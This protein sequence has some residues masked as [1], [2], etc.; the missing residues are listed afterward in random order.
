[1]SINWRDSVLEEKSTMADAI[2]TLEKIQYGIVF[3]LSHGDELVGIVTDGDI[4]RSLMSGLGLNSSILDILN[5]IPVTINVNHNKNEVFE[6][7]NDLRVEH[8]PVLDGKKLVGVIKKDGSEVSS[9]DNLVFIM[10]GGFGTRLKPLTDNIPKPMLNVGNRPVLETIIHEFKKQGFWNFYISTH[11]L[12]EKIQE[13]FEDGKK[14]GVSIK[15]VHENKPLGTAGA[16][17]LLPD[18]AKKNPLILMNGDLLTKV[19]FKKILDFHEKNNC[20][21]TL[22]VRQYDL[23]V[24][25]GVVDCDESIVKKIIE[26]PIHKF[27][28]NAGIYVLSSDI[29]ESVKKDQL[30][31][32]PTLLN[33]EIGN[34]RKVSNFPVH[35]YWLDIGRMDQFNQAQKDIQNIFYD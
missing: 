32:M 20:S 35:E 17:S 26:K 23:E 27:F 33:R 11:H 19:N 24:P 25:F 31:D 4:R 15:Y 22:C 5:K 14:M 18:D 13:Y 7:F 34:K 29:V 21:A 3:V 12:P 10:A 8:L 9:Y 30:L 2:N 1:M 16:L 6:K 28:I